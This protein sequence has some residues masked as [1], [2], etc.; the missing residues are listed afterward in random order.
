[1]RRD[2]SRILWDLVL[3]AMCWAVWTAQND[4]IF[5]NKPF[6]A[7]VV[8]ESHLFLIFTWVKA[9]WKSCPYS[10]DKFAR[11]FIK[12]T[13]D[14]KEAPRLVVPW[15]PPQ[16]ITLKFNVDGSFQAGHAGIGGILRNSAGYVLGYF[17][18]KVVAQRADEA[19]V[20]AILYALLYCQQFVVFNVEV[21]SDSMLAV[22]W[23]KGLKIRPWKMTN[24]L[25]M[26]DYLMPVV[27]C[28]GVRH[29]LRE[30]NLEADALAK[31]GC[32][33]SE[34]VWIYDGQPLV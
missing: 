32:F 11:G 8:W 21:E 28:S 2:T 7:E 9:W 25:N 33:A 5:N 13:I 31:Q 10:A 20:L 1:M 26:I 15:V 17:S 30:G 12:I 23:V 19:E 6:N 14:D 22:G 18:R 4:L 24:E 16:G 3:Y 34:P 27:L 29:I